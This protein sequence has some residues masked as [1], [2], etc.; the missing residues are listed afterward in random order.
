MR[1]K[2]RDLERMNRL[3]GQELG[4][5]PAHGMDGPKYRWVYSEDFVHHMV[6]AGK[7]DYG[8]MVVRDEAGLDSGKRLITLKRVTALRKM[9]K[10]ADNQWLISVW[11]WA[12]EELWRKHFGT[13]LEWPQRGMY[14]P[15]DG[16]T[17]NPGVVP[18]TDIT[19]SFIHHMRHQLNTKRADMDA[20][21]EKAIALE[22]KA[23]GDLITDKLDDLTSAF[24][25]P[26]PGSRM[27]GIS[28]PSTEYKKNYDAAMHLDNI[29]KKGNIHLA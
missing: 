16:T 4:W 24:G 22:E 20:Q 9:C 7:R 3:L 23:Q 17:L 29:S 14:F 15:V 8:E 12:P 27:G 5:N 2:E 26:K 19:F 11:K 1:I 18:T 21:A 25:N 13:D 6:L 10:F 28:T